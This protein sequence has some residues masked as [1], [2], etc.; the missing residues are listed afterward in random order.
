MEP[1]EKLIEF[2]QAKG[3]VRSGMGPETLAEFEALL[4]AV[5]AEAPY[6]PMPRVKGRNAHLVCGPCPECNYQFDHCTQAEGGP[7]ANG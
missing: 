6:M 4:A 3:A 7:D 1:I 5:E 2:L